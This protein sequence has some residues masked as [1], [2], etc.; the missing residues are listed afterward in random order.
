MLNLKK[1]LAVALAAATALTFAPVAQLAAPVSAYAENTSV[2]VT[3]SA[4]GKSTINPG[5][6]TYAVIAKDGK[7]LGVKVTA[8]TAAGGSVTSLATAPSG[9]E[10]VFGVDEKGV[11]LTFTGTEATTN[12]DITFIVRKIS[13]T[14][15]SETS[16]A[17]DATKKYGDDI[18]INVNVSG[19]ESKFTA[20]T[21]A[22]LSADKYNNSYLDLANGK[23]TE[24]TIRRG[25]SR[26]K[27]ETDITVTSKNNY[28]TVGSV[29]QDTG[30]VT[31]TGAIV[32]TDTITV[33]EVAKTTSTTGKSGSSSKETT[34]VKDVI[35]STTFTVNVKDSATNVNAFQW[36]NADGKAVYYGDKTSSFKPATEKGTENTDYY[37]SKSVD[38]DTLVNKSVQL[39]VSAAGAVTY[40]STDPSI[41][42]VDSTGKITAVKNGI[43]SVV[44][45]V[46]PSG[47]LGAAQYTL[48]VNVSGTARDSI[49]A[50]V[51]G[52]DV[53]DS[54]NPVNLD[55]STSTAVNAV[56]S[57]KIDATSAAGLKMT[58]ALYS[59]ADTSSNTNL[60]AGNSNDI[61][62][63]SADGTLT[64]GAK[65]G[66]VYVKIS[67]ATKGDI[68]GAD[69]IVKVVV[70]KLPEAVIALDD[71]NLDLKNH[72]TVTLAPT[73]NIA[74]AVFS[75][76]LDEDAA[77]A[78]VLV[79]NKLTA[80]K[81]GAGKLTVTEPATATTRTTTKTVN[82]TVSNEIAKKASDLKVTSAKTVALTKGASSQITYTVAT[83]S[84]V[85]FESSDPTVAA[86][87]G[88]SIQALKAGTA[89]ITVKT[90]ETED[91]LAGSDFVVV[92]VTEAAVKPA[93]VTGLKV[94]NAKGAKVTVKFTASKLANV[95][96]YVQKK[97]SGKT[98]GK[99]VGSNKTTLSVK[100]GATVKVR[101]KAYYYDAA[102]NK[103]VGSYSA[104]K[105]LKTDKK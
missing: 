14:P 100:K 75:Y 47:S 30:K 78:A 1:G 69:K 17:V 101:V 87:S 23:P 7:N 93:K 89:I 41:A 33:S 15:I 68:T 61:A 12:G 39:N 57:A 13:S 53:D 28:V 6:G 29:A 83:G 16:A 35:A 46:A 79:G 70:N 3:T 92:T 56:K 65:E 43:T 37:L 55:L 85:S 91:T 2:K 59:A 11:T 19:V 27:D 51:G 104:W 60:V 36:K 50:K 4:P 94:T 88:S 42:S 90:P 34:K 21:V 98:S 99:S 77:N 48:G 72:K 54:K 67:T 18:D 86:V 64:A 52:K 62:T 96:Y 10:L 71:V 26:T 58:F 74:N 31:L 45:Y 9:T 5:A 103:L 22:N 84:A 32:G 73:S 8:K 66:T 95:K 80:T 20:P 82:V 49:N 24:L 81:V 97:V 25:D 38:L 105:S 76:A 44:V 102:G 63:L 40:L